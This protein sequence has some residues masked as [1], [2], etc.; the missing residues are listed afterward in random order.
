MTF[1]EAMATLA[2][3]RLGEALVARR[4]LEHGKSPLINVAI[5][6]NWDRSLEDVFKAMAR[7]IRDDGR[8][9]TVSALDQIRMGATDLLYYVGN[10]QGHIEPVR[11]AIVATRRKE[12]KWHPIKVEFSADKRSY[13]F[14]EHSF[15]EG[16]K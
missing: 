2:A 4:T 1:E 5:Q 3:E 16:G 14:R 13:R 12:G 8:S 7:R 6:G 9:P 11:A 15:E 10:G